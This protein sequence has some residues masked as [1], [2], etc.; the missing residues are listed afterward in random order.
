MGITITEKLQKL[1]NFYIWSKNTV[2]YSLSC[3]VSLTT[4]DANDMQV[5]TTTRYR[6][7]VVCPWR[8]ALCE[9]RSPCWF[10]TVTLEPY[11]TRVWIQTKRLKPLLLWG[12]ALCKISEMLMTVSTSG[13][14]SETLLLPVALL[15]VLLPLCKMFSLYHRSTW[16]CWGKAAFLKSKTDH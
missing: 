5:S 13:F 14:K 7:Q 1:Y 6:A 15:L 11:S 3:L 2:T 16:I 12:L 4:C 10:W 8:S 9:G